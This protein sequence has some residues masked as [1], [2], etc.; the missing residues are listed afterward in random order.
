M[1]PCKDT[2]GRKSAAVPDVPW[3]HAGQGDCNI[4]KSGNAVPGQK[5]YIAASHACQTLDGFCTV[6]PGNTR[7]GWK[8][9]QDPIQV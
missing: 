8:G 2:G 1:T 3:C 4:G 9:S 6:L 5:Q 7:L